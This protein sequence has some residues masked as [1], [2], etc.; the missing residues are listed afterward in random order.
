VI[1]KIVCENFKSYGGLKE[2]GLF[3]KSFSAIIGP[4]GNGKS[5]IIDALTPCCLFLDIEL[6]KFGAKK[7]PFLF[8]TRNCCPTLRVVRDSELFKNPR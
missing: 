1:E 8:T 7:S 3:H 5:N 6:Q 2:M 4:N